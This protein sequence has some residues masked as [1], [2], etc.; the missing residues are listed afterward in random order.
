MDSNDPDY[1]KSTLKCRKGHEFCSCGRILHEGSCYQDEKAFK[2]FINKEKIK[3]CPKRGFLIKKNKG[4]NHMTCGNPACRYEFCWICMQETVP[5]HYDY[6]SCAG[7]Q[8][9]DTESLVY[10]HPCLAKFLFILLVISM[11]QLDT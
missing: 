4:C 11:A 7:K 9:L 10:D 8:F 5:N 2:K 1:I 3:K 6:G